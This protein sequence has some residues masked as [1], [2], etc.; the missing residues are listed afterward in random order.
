MTAVDATERGWIRHAFIWLIA[1]NVAVYVAQIAT[2]VHW[3]TPDPLGLL[4][5]GGNA[6]PFTLDDEWWRAFTSMFLHGGLLH[7]ALNMYMLW[8]CGALAERAFGS[9]RFLVLYSF[10]GLCGSFASALWHGTHKLGGASLLEIEDRLQFVVGVGASGALMGLA[11]AYL[12]QRLL[13]VG[14]GEEPE[15]TNAHR[16]ILL[17]IALTIG[18]G[19][20]IPGV[21]QAAHL[22]GLFGGVVGG[23]LLQSHRSPPIPSPSLVMTSAVVAL[24]SMMV[25]TI[26]RRAPSDELRLLRAQVIEELRGRERDAVE[27]QRRDAEAT[28]ARQDR[29]QLDA[30]VA[31]DRDK[32]DVVDAKTA[33]GIVWPL[34][35]STESPVLL[36]RDGTSAYVSDISGNAVLRMDMSSGSMTAVIKG[37]S[38][39]SKR[40]A[41]AGC[42]DNLCLGRGAAEMWLSP[43][44]RTL[45]VSSIQE[46][47]V[48]VVDLT[49]EALTSSIGVGRFPRVMVGTADGTRAFVVNALDNSVSMLDL[50]SSK[51]IGEPRELAGGRSGFTPVSRSLGIWLSPSEQQLYV[52]DDIADQIEALDAATLAPIYAAPLEHAFI[53]GAQSGNKQKLAVL[54]DGGV[55]MYLL[56]PLRLQRRFDI[57]MRM[58]ASDLALDQTGDLLAVSAAELNVVLLIRLTTRKILGVYPTGGRPR[59]VAFAARDTRILVQNERDRSVSVLDVTKSLDAPDFVAKVGGEFLCER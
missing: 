9:F 50:T 2:G 25:W 16:A 42:S 6:A 18:M 24:G 12:V 20:L 58:G 21:D 43:D 44:E 5:W 55:Y 22:G 23:L 57:C 34:N 19:F 3:L 54:T 37:G 32:I 8:I 52:A 47:H 14:E 35:V 56:E 36:S 46:D 40:K 31:S 38:T 11:S 4:R 28:V 59:F 48:G 51:T 33:A 39:Q 45:Y 17:T 15:P 27:Q 13:K 30:I 7:L 1:I 53:A 26:V 29:E 49:S 10:S 41:I